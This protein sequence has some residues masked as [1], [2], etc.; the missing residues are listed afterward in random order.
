MPTDTEA[1]LAMLK[2]GNR[3]F[4]EGL[5]TPHYTPEQRTASLAGQE[6]VAVIIGCSDSRV[7]VEVVFDAG[8]GELFVVRSAGHVIANAGL[9]SIRFAVEHL[10]TRTIVVLGHEDCGAVSAALAGYSPKW[11]A[12][13]VDHIDVTGVDPADAPEG[14]DNPMLTAA[15]DAHVRNTVADLDEWF[16]EL[17]MSCEPPTIVGAAYKLSTGE[18]HWL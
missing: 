17:D 8:V 16:G 10:H 3:R 4:V 15:V 2:A 13:I 7:P 5:T 1:A 12:P 9:A 11:L 18:V 6:P 14:A